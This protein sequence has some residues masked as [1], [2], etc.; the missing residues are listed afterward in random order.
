MILYEVQIL[1]EK[2]N[3][4]LALV[5][6]EEFKDLICDNMSYLEIKGMVCSY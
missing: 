5:H 2:R 1:M 3:Y 6:L 4:D